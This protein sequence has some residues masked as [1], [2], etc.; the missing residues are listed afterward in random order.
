[1]K[2]N[3]ALNINTVYQVDPTRTTVLR[4]RFVADVTR[5][6]KRVMRLVQESVVAN[7]CFGLKDEA[8]RLFVAQA[9]SP[10]QFAFSRSSAKVDGFMD[11]LNIQEEQN[12]LEI[13]RRPGSIRGIEEAWTDTYTQSAYQK[14]IQRADAELKKAGVP[15]LDVDQLGQKM[16]LSVLMNQ[17]MHAD[18]V[19]LLYTR[20]F[21]ELKGISTAMDQQISRVLSQWLI[22]G[23]GLVDKGGLNEL[24]NILIGRIDKIGLT[25][26]KMMART[27]IIRAHHSA[28][29]A[30]YRRA[31]LE[32]VKV[33][34]EFSTAGYNV[35]EEC[36]SLEGRI[37]TLDEIENLIPVHPNC[38]VDGQVK[39]YTSDG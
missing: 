2:N 5:R 37:F 16:P 34:A 4:S 10:G 28:N 26:A 3:A 31:G 7:D 33:K 22:D 38:L 6:F 15:V 21:N 11:W 36:A 27:E 9:A 30:E 20:T 18:R 23:R 12:I 17:S 13:I 14:G 35:C 25:R 29:I 32:G 1:M 39:V 19:G 8:P 24:S